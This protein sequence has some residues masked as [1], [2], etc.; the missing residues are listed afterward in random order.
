MAHDTS[1]GENAAGA[2]GIKAAT[3]EALGD[4]LSQLERLQYRAIDRWGGQEYL[5]AVNIYAEGDQAY[6]YRNYRLAG[7][8]YREASRMLE[9]FFDR[10]ESVFE[11]TLAAAREAL[12]AGDPSEAVRLFDLAVAITPGH[13]EA[14]AGLVRARNLESVLSLMEQG[15]RYEARERHSMRP[16]F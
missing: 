10:I 3:D 7:E 12:E 14:E 5:D 15:N 4:L 16:K 2:G 13:R 8:K 6:V 9:P 1:F 11:E